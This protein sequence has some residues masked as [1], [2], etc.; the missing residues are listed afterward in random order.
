MST[1]NSNSSAYPFIEESKSE[2][3]NGCN[4]TTATTLS[5]G[6]TKREIFCLHNSVADTGDEE[7]DAIIRKGLHQKAAMVAMQGL[8]A[9]DDDRQAHNVA[10]QAVQNVDALLAELERTK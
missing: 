8:L 5:M 7:L 6:L 9:K 2:A 10:L 3:Y 4:F 1:I